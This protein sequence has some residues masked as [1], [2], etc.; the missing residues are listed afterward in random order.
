MKPALVHGA[1]PINPHKHPI[2]ASLWRRGARHPSPASSPRTPGEYQRQINDYFG[3]RAPL[4]PK[5]SGASRRL[6][7]LLDLEF[8]VAVCLQCW[9]DRL[10]CEAHCKVW[11]DRGCALRVP[12]FQQ[13]KL[14]SVLEGCAGGDQ[15]E[16][17]VGDRSIV[18][19]G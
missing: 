6:D 16:N 15:F 12:A 8:P 13:G 14:G 18:V 7:R 17:F 10:V 19:R 1:F 5:F 2:R 9:E 4:F 11:H 3:A